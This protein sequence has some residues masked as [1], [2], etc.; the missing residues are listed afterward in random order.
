MLW[1]RCTFPLQI[2]NSI[3]MKNN[4]RMKTE[5]FPVINQLQIDEL[6]SRMNLIKYTYKN[7]STPKSKL[8]KKQKE[9]IN[10]YFNFTKRC[11]ISVEIELWLGLRSSTRLQCDTEN[12]KHLYL[13]ENRKVIFNLLSNAF[14]DDDVRM[15]ILLD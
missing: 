5:I 8:V 3:S 13:D 12:L 4:F 10:L 14:V 15:H 1:M 6:Y 7:R 9:F 2:T 11:L